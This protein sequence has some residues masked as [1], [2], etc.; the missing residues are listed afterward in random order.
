[1]LGGTNEN[2]KEKGGIE[3][4]RGWKVDI[5]VELSPMSKAMTSEKHRNHAC[6]FMVCACA[7]GVRSSMQSD[8]SERQLLLEFNTVV[9]AGWYHQV[10]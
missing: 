5:A 3:S 2:K 10:A 9:L 8:R 4:H 7:W 6:A 1:M